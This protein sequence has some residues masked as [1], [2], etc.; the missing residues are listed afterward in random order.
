M[1]DQQEKVDHSTAPNIGDCEEEQAISMVDVLA[2]EKQL[3]ED[4]NAVLGD[5]DMS[6]CTYTQVGLNFPVF[7][8][9]YRCPK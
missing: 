6:S 2:E 4:A 8:T 5:S 1:A 9:I 3:E 7:S